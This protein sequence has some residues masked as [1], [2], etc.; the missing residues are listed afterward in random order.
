MD[1][2]LLVALIVC[3]SHSMSLREKMRNCR[4][5]SNDL[6][7]IFSRA[8][9]IFHAFDMK[10]R[11]VATWIWHLTH[12]LGRSGFASTVAVWVWAGSS[13]TTNRNSEI[14]NFSTVNLWHMWFHLFDWIQ[15]FFMEGRWCLPNFVAVKNFSFS[16]KTHKILWLLNVF[17]SSSSTRLWSQWRFFHPHN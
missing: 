6:G 14:R 9:L 3:R 10:R 11:K 1:L 15:K 13:G 5:L 16:Q 4:K 7:N 17:H 12:K 2:I 8:G